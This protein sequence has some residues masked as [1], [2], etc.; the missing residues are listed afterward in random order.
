[1]KVSHNQTTVPFPIWKSWITPEWSI[2]NRGSNDTDSSSVFANREKSLRTV[3]S[4]TANADWITLINSPRLIRSVNKGRLFWRARGYQIP[5]L[6]PLINYWQ[7]PAN[8]FPWLALNYKT[9]KLDGGLTCSDFSVLRGCF[10]RSDHIGFL[11]CRKLVGP[12]R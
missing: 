1:M 5:G 3:A 4:N 6:R 8:S 7:V 10:D 2:G 12:D 11:P 9:G